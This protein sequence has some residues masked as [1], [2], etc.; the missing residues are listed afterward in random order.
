MSSCSL[1]T[2]FPI[3][4]FLYSHFVFTPA[5]IHRE[6]ESFQLLHLAACS[7][8]NDSI[9]AFSH[10]HLFIFTDGSKITGDTS[11]HAKGTDRGGG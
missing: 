8:P 11:T 10:S 2:P 9:R 5:S 1:L 4:T 3:P 7:K 6:M